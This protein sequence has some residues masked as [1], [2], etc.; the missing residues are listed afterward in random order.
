MACRLGL[1]EPATN[2]ASA[3]AFQSPPTMR[4]QRKHVKNAL[5]DAPCRRR[6]TRQDVIKLKLPSDRGSHSLVVAWLCTTSVDSPA[7][8]QHRPMALHIQ[9]AD[10]ILSVPPADSSGFASITTSPQPLLPHIAAQWDIARHSSYRYEVG[11]RVEHGT[12]LRPPQTPEWF[13]LQERNKA[14]GLGSL[15]VE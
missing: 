1:G 9:L 14:D 13:I 15:T 8:R 10:P 5:T 2:A 4:C 7:T 11:W 3:L 12:P 6:H